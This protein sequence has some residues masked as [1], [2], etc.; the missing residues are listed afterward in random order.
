MKKITLREVAVA[1][2]VSTA[3]ASWAINHVKQDGARISDETRERVLRVAQE[4]GYKPNA[5][6]KGL[7]RGS[8]NLLGF[9]TDD[10]ATTPFAGQIIQGAQD[11]AWRQGRLLLII[12]TDGDAQVE[13]QA[14]ETLREQQVAGVVYSTWYHHGIACPE[15]LKEMPAVLVNCFAEGEDF[16]AVVPDE[17]TGGYDATAMLL[18]AGHRR[19]AFINTLTPSPARRLRYQGYQDAL[20]TYGVALDTNLVMNAHP[21]QEGGYAAVDAI[22][23]SGVTGVFCH[24][25]RVAMGLYD[26]LHMR[27]VM[28][29]EQLSIVGFDNQEVIAAHLHPALTSIGLPHYEL[30][31]RG[32]RTL[33]SALETKH[34]VMTK[35]LVPCPSVKRDS[36][37]QLQP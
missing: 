17:Y 29:P 25:D 18:A 32:V 31:V 2:H 35:Q 23:R 21:D 33:M 22:L 6:A 24:N 27:G 14:F 36:V 7:S 9:I 10:V 34:A 1:A 30:G 28:I 15:A 8:S 37:R 12:N 3:T 26:G 19:I 16:P 4:L 20:K 13:S 11:E 5:L